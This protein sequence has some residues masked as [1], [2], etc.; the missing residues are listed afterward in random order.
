MKCIAPSSKFGVT[1]SQFNQA[2][3]RNLG[4]FPGDFMVELTFEE[5]ARF[6]ITNCDLKASRRADTVLHLRRCERGCG[7]APGA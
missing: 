6:E 7:S 2:V 3:R 1:P 4:R 5:T